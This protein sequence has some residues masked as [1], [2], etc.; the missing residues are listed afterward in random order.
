M[1]QVFE[2]FG[3]NAGYIVSVFTTLFAVLGMQ[4]KNMRYIIISQL[5]ANGLLGLQYVL[6]DR[7]SAS[8]IV[9]IAIL[10]TVVSFV[11][12]YRK[13]DFPVWLT[14][15][16]MLAFA[17]VSFLTYTSWQ[18]LL[19]LAAVLFFAVAI[20]QKNSAICRLCSA[21][22]STLWLIYDVMCAPSAVL[23][24]SVILAF[25]IF[26]ILHQ[27]RAQWAA[28]FKRCKKEKTPENKDT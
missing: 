20:V 12:I 23:T 11:L 16:F 5:L 1:Q 27:D 3:E 17:A 15:L 9:M 7:L 4:F 6:E 21:I 25:I 10:Q 2:F 24:H 22:N 8:G 26:A 19:P 14:V 18:D 28:F 13:K